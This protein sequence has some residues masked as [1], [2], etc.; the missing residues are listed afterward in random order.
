MFQM[1]NKMI[2]MVVM[3]MDMDIPYRHLEAHYIEICLD[4]INQPQ[5]RLL[6]YHQVIILEKEQRKWLK[7][8]LEW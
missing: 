2:E 7:R 1:K 5:P 3:D 8:P 6:P 4:L